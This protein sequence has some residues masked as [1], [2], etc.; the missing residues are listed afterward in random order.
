MFSFNYSKECIGTSLE[1]THYEVKYSYSKFEEISYIGAGG[2][3]MYFK[4]C[5]PSK[6]SPLNNLRATVALCHV[7]GIFTLFL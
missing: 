1:L 7:I 3:G 2:G 4:I 6:V 5:G